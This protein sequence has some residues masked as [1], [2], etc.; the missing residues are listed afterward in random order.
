[1][2]Q[3][4]LWKIRPDLDY[5]TISEQGHF[6]RLRKSGAYGFYRLKKCEAEECEKD[7]PKSKKYCSIECKEEMEDTNVEDVSKDLDEADW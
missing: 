4:H 7:I 6:K 1:M 2:K 3:T 5:L